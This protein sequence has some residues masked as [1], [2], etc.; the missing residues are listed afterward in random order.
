MCRDKIL[1]TILDVELYQKV[2]RGQGNMVII[3]TQIAPIITC[4]QL[5]GLEYMNVTLVAFSSTALPVSP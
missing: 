3:R 1:Y 4:V 5:C 2:S